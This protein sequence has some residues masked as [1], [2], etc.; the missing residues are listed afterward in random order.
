MAS[1]FYPTKPVFFSLTESYKVSESHFTPRL[2]EYFSER[3]RHLLGIETATLV[4]SDYMD[5]QP[6]LSPEARQTLLN[7]IMK[8]HFAYQL[9]PQTLFLSVRL[10]DRFLSVEQVQVEEVQLLGMSCLLIASKME[11]TLPLSTRDLCLCVGDY[12]S[13]NDI[14]IAERNILCVLDYTTTLPSSLSFYE[15]MIQT[16]SPAT[17]T[18]LYF[19]ARYFLELL[20]YDQTGALSIRPSLQAAACVSRAV[21]MTQS[22]GENWCPSVSFGVTPEEVLVCKEHLLTVYMTAMTTKNHPVRLK[23]SSSAYQG[24]ALSLS[25]TV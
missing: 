3:L 16:L 4:R 9:S 7:W 24:I 20:I 21:E 15:M 6:E 10:L 23:F 8:V 14:I 12:C 19:L 11:D 25:Y 18:N 5:L 13:V 2:D 22:N 1:Q 17:N